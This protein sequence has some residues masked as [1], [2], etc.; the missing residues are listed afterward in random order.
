MYFRVYPRKSREKTYCKIGMKNIKFYLSYVF[1]NGVGY[2]AYLTNFNGSY[3]RIDSEDIEEVDKRKTSLT[4]GRT[5]TLRIKR[6]Y[7]DRIKNI[8]DS[9]I[10]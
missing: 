3:E 4:P 8:L 10:T 7:N 2:Y 5:D 1:V 6:Y 9:R